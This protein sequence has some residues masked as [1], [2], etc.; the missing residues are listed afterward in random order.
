MTPF[1]STQRH[2]HCRVTTSARRIRLRHIREKLLRKHEEM[3]IMRDNSDE[4]FA[5]MTH[6][7][8]VSRLKELYIPFNE[9]HDS[10]QR[11][12]DAF[13]TRH[14]KV[15]HDH[16]SIAFIYDTAFYYT[17]QEMKDLKLMFRLLYRF[18]KST[19]LGAHHLQLKTSH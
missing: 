5:N 7:E 13:R 19:S 12:K 1:V 10:Q 14:L 3:G 15:W 4:F 9:S 2:T 11:L 16:S 18:Q 8:V 6:D 17:T